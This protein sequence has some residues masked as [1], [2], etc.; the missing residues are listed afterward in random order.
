MQNA[1]LKNVSIQAHTGLHVGYASV[2]VGNVKIQAAQG[3]A[4]EKL[5]RAKITAK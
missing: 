2:S 4:I 5:G 3:A 1:V